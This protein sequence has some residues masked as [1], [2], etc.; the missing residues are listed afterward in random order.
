MRIVFDPGVKGCR[1]DGDE[2]YV[3]MTDYGEVTAENPSIL[4]GRE[5]PVGIWKLMRPHIRNFLDCV[6]TRKQ[7]ISH[8]ES[9]HR[10]HSLVHCANLCLRLGRKL[11][12]DSDSEWF[13]G[14]EKANEYVS[15]K[16]REPWDIG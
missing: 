6:K 1:F 9:A 3:A 2:G 10:A 14:D 11:R 16:M 15:R 12:W 5:P 8:P 7:T 4:D 13:V